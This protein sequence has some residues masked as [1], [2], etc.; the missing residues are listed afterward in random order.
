MSRLSENT[1]FST[2]ALMG[3][4]YAREYNIWRLFVRMMVNAVADR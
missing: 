4:F 1:L 3:N 2:R